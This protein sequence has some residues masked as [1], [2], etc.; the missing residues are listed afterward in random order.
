MAMSATYLYASSAAATH[1]FGQLSSAR[2]RACLGRLVARVLR[3]TERPQRVTIAV[4]T[5]S[6]IIQPVGDQH[7]ADRIFLRLFAAGARE[8]AYIDLVFVRVGRGIA[9]LSPAAVGAV[10]DTPLRAGCCGRSPAGSR[11]TSDGRRDQ[12]GR[13]EAGRKRRLR[14]AH[15]AHTS[16]GI[17]PVR[18]SNPNT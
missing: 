3:A 4:R 18:I 10:F 13:C 15:S 9:I 11:S 7:A 6:A 12:A 17:S 5:Y 1:W 14:S 2:T 8:T 16:S